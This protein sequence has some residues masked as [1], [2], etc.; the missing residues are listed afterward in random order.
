MMQAD[1]HLRPDAALGFVAALQPGAHAT[2]D[3]GEHDVID[4]DALAVRLPDALE[5]GERS[6]REGD[7][8]RRPDAPVERRSGSL[9]C[10]FP[11]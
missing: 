1:G 7:P 6:G 2:R 4:R 9:W 8:A 3:H 11:A 10:K 5:L